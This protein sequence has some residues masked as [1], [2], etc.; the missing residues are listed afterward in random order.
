MALPRAVRVPNFIHADT[1]PLPTCAS[2]SRSIRHGDARDNCASN[3]S[4]MAGR[5]S[6][7][8]KFQVKPSRS[9]RNPFSTNYAAAELEPPAFSVS[10][11]PAG[12]RGDPRWGALLGSKSV[13]CG[14][15]NAVT[16]CGRLNDHWTLGS[17]RSC[18]LGPNQSFAG[19]S[20][21]IR[22]ACTSPRLSRLRLLPL[23]LL[24]A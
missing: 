11:N 17:G 21:T 4:E 12:Q 16:A 18:A 8:T 10:T 20:R 22:N 15:L 5:P 6:G 3:I 2:P 24:E 9:R 23:S 14:F 19:W 13:R 7:E 1:P